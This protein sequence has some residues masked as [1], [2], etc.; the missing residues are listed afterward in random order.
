M[1]TAFVR[2]E[3]LTEEI[4]YTVLSNQL[5]ADNAFDAVDDYAQSSILPVS[6]LAVSVADWLQQELEKGLPA[7]G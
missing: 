4:Q 2:I 7:D 5:V 3:Q 1:S 6:I